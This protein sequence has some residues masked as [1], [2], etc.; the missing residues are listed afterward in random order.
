MDDQEFF[1]ELYQL[2]AQCSGTGFWFAKENDLIGGHCVMLDDVTPAEAPRPGLEVASFARQEDATFIAT[3]YT[4]L[5]D[6]LRRAMAALD[7]AERLDIERDQ[8]VSEL[9]EVTAENERL[10]ADLECFQ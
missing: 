7:E 6:I 8:V 3:I 5:P 9:R 4:A 10:Q 2:W 1:D